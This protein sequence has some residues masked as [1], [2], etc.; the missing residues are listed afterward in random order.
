M[1]TVTHQLED[2][3][4]RVEPWL[5]L[6]KFL[7]KKE[8]PFPFFSSAAVGEDELMPTGVQLYPS[9]S[10]IMILPFFTFP[11]MTQ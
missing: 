1:A 8:V 6:I 10:P 2:T 11:A 5:L 7:A 9:E 4:T 3:V